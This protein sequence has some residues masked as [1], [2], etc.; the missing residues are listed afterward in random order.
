MYK[1]FY[2]K[3]SLK[4]IPKLKSAHLDDK[5]KKLIDILREIYSTGLCIRLTMKIKQL[6]L[7]V[8]GRI[9]NIKLNKKTA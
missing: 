8:C 2:T 6:K 5:A 1:I 7:S 4:S 3:A 9:M